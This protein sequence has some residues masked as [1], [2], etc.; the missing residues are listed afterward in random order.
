M[1]KLKLFILIFFVTTSLPLAFVIWQSYS[2][3][4]QE[5]RAQLNFFSLT[6]FDQME[7]E[8]AKLV[9]AEELRAV[10]EYQHFLAGSS[11]Q[12]T[13]SQR[14]PLA[15]PSYPDYILGYLQNNPDGSMQTPLIADPGNVAD[16][17]KALMGRL[18]RANEIFNTKKFIIPQPP[19]RKEPSP[20]QAENEEQLQEG[21]AERFLRSVKPQKE[22]VYMGKKSQ[23]VEEITAEQALNVASREE[24]VQQY[25]ESEQLRSIA[26]APAASSDLQA[27]IANLTGS[28]R[29]L[30]SPSEYR[31]RQSADTVDTGS[32]P[33][34]VADKFQVEVA[35]FQSVALQD[36][37]V[38]MFRRIVIDNQIYRQGFILLITPLLEHLVDTHFSD[39]PL[40]EFTTL[41][42]QRW[43]QGRLYDVVTAGISSEGSDF[44]N[45]HV[46]AAPF[47]F[48]SVRLS[49]QN[50]PASPARRSLNI[51]L[52]A[53]AVF[54]LLGLVAIYQSAHAIVALSEKR[55]QFVSAVSHELKT[56]LTN[57]RMYI[58][59]L[60]QGIAS[61]PEREHEYLAI[62]DAESSRLTNLINN[63]LELSK[64]E[65]KQR[66]FHLEEGTLDDVLADVEALMTPK[67]NQ[68][69]FSLTIHK[70]EIAPFAYDREVLIQILV[71]LIE[72]SLKFGKQS[73]T[74]AITISVGESD[75]LVRLA[76]SDS[77]PGIPRHALSKIFTDFYRVDNALTRTTGGTGIGLALVK[78]LITALGGSVDA[79]NND[80]PGCTITVSLP[81]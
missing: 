78:K 75:G 14:S 68:D 12:E 73:A 62:L 6:L 44:V 70:T 64:L 21:F 31:S 57:I 15:G 48:L 36:D 17:E 25:A 72:N 52:A 74:R 77:G 20:V 33:S 45:R 63:V 69:G 42:L 28:A 26:Q 8:L 30:S 4:Q 43:D 16:G 67:I 1:N 55:S 5:E 39:Q 10:D 60:E 50:I 66:H 24:R 9:Q 13:S 35:P 47:D 58:E 38:Y 54:M 27:G 18:R 3:L 79:A 80:G 53:L 41:H 81:K 49:A 71:N 65:K 22:R 51:A 46:F 11:Q 37:H 40:A 61:T 34:I 76:V 7:E 29:S 59:M 19:L 2:G 56:P 32:P 23:R